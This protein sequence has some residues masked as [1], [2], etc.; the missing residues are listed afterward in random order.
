MSLLSEV[1][2]EDGFHFAE[3]KIYVM[4][5]EN[6]V[7][8]PARKTRQ[9]AL[10]DELELKKVAARNLHDP[11]LSE[12]WTFADKLQGHKWLQ[13]DFFGIPK[14]P[15]PTRAPKKR[16]VPKAAPGTKKGAE[17]DSVVEVTDVDGDPAKVQMALRQAFKKYGT[18]LEVKMD[19]A[20]GIAKV[21]YASV[22]GAEAL[23]AAAAQG[24]HSVGEGTVRVRCTGASKEEWRE[25]PAA[26]KALPIEGEPKKKKLRP[27]ERFASRS[28]E[29][30]A[31]E[32]EGQAPAPEPKVAEPEPV[33]VPEKPEPITASADWT[34]ISA[35]AS[36]EDLAVAAGEVQ[37][38]QDMAALI[39]KPFSS[40]RKALKALR[41]KWHPDKNPENKEVAT[42]VFQFLQAH[43]AWLEHHGISATKQE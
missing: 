28:G 17:W 11:N 34:R 4:G 10:K 8:G 43:D 19:K 31:G 16:E 36:E 15:P 7:G 25:F 39:E 41:L 3:L 21:R 27:N 35:D 24:F 38:S 22:G 33:V 6:K 14:D 12:V 30:D 1:V 5:L 40:Q 37:V 9:E 20:L 18:V 32:T 29:P 2:Q 26:R 42:R 13:K 23:M